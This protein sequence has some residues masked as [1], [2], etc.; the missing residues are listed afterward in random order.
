MRD[1]AARR[2]PHPPKL[3]MEKSGFRAHQNPDFSMINRTGWG[4]GGGRGGGQVSGAEGAV[5]QTGQAI[6][7]DG[8]VGEQGQ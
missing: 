3:I 6:G 5:E 1:A 2:I 7:V 8:L 4:G